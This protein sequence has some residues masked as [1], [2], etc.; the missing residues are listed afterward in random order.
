MKNWWEHTIALKTI[1]S[2]EGYSIHNATGDEFLVN[3]DKLLLYDPVQ[4]NQFLLRYDKIIGWEFTDDFACTDKTWIAA[5]PFLQKEIDSACDC[6]DGI[7]N[8]PIDILMQKI[9]YEIR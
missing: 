9:G 1:D 8:D 3:F 5:S 7:N 4:K 2:F 6:K